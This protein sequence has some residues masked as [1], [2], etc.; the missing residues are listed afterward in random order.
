MTIKKLTI[1]VLIIVF[2]IFYRCIPIGNEESKKSQALAQGNTLYR[3]GIYGWPISLIH[4]QK[5]IS[6][7]NVTNLEPIGVID[8]GID[9]SNPYLSQSQYT[10]DKRQKSFTQSHG[11]MVAG[12]LSATGN[13]QSTP[14]GVIPKVK[15]VNIQ[16]GSSQSITINDLVKGIQ[17]AESMHLKVVNIS[18]GTKDNS[19]L[20]RN[21][22]EKAIKHG[23]CIVAASGD[24]GGSQLDYPAAYPGVIA[25]GAV[26]DNGFLIKNTNYNSSSTV[27]APG[28]AI[29]TTI[30]GNSSSDVSWFTGSSAATPIVSALCDILVSRNPSLTPAQVKNIVYKTSQ[31][32]G[33]ENVV[34]FQKAY[35]SS[36]TY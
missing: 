21:A 24:D 7:V 10:F 36:R 32:G 33:G 34:N 23:M 35:I 25:V 1:I 19:S 14:R 6:S 20:L 13:G 17:K 4:A 15:L 18:L 8:T 31:S 26:N 3:N 16:V 12:I 28:Y 5:V 22:V 11:T 9:F 27:T 30:P 2:C 29:L